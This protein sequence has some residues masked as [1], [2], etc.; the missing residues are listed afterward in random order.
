M[1]QASLGRQPFT[2]AKAYFIN[3]GFLDEFGIPVPTPHHYYVNDGVYS[4]VNCMQFIEQAV[5]SGVEAIYMLRGPPAP[6]SQN[7]CELDNLYAMAVS[8]TNKI[9]GHLIKTCRMDIATPCD[10]LIDTVKMLT[11]QWGDHM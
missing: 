2:Q 10:Y 1:V 3:K 8:F 11:T 4:D 7:S 5:A 6:T 9:L